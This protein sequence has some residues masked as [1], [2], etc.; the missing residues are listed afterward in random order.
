MPVTAHAGGLPAGHSASAAPRVLALGGE[1]FGDRPGGLNR[2]LAGLVRALGDAGADMRAV[3]LGPAVGAPSAFEAVSSAGAPLVRRLLAVRRAAARHAGAVDVVDVHFALYGLLPLLASRLR[4]VPVV[5][6]F[7]GPWAAESAV[8]GAGRVAVAAKRAVERA[9]Y[10]RADRVVVLSRAFGDIAVRDYGVDAAR[11]AVIPP[12]VDLDRF[13]PGDRDACRR[14]LGVGPATF[15]VVCARRLVARMGI[16]VLLRAWAQVQAEVPDAL[17]VIA[18]EGSARHGLAA[19]AAGVPRPDGVRLVGRVDDAVLTDLYRAADCTVVPTRALEGF[20]LVVL[21]S[22]ACGTPAV[23]AGV[24]GLPDAVAGLAPDLVVPAEDEQAL[25]ARLVAAACGQLPSRQRCRAH[26]ETFGW[27]EV[28]GRHTELLRQVAPP[29]PSG[30]RL[31][32]AYVDHCAVLSGAELALAR[33]LGALDVDAHVIL[34]EDGPLRARL[35]S[36][37]ATVHVL[38]M[39]TGL[40][41]LRRHRAGSVAAARHAADLALYVVRLTGLLRR[42]GP[43]VVHTNSLKAALYGG[44]AGRLAG[45]PVVWHVR[46]RIAPDYLP[47]AAVRLVRLAGRVLPSALIANS[48]GTL[49]TVLPAVA[50]P[51]PV[52]VGARRRRRSGGPLRVGIVGRLAP[53]KGQDVFLRAFARAFADDGTVAVVVGSALF[54]EEEYAGDLKTLVT[55]LGLDGRVE[56]RGFCDDVGAELARMDVVVHASTVPEPFGQVVVEAMAAGAAVVVPDRGG[57]A[58]V[59]EDGV[60]GVLYPMGDEDGLVAALHRVAGDAGLRARLGAAGRTAAQ[61]YRPEVVAG[62]V[63]SVYRAVLERAG[64]P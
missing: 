10:R 54:G 34:G 60:T 1:W 37:G 26:A 11:V 40:R 43:D 58:E 23:V 52:D 39:A 16:D 51:S 4:R 62:E 32:V 47:A 6:H 38:P 22:L 20:G 49:A 24:G 29:D 61:R 59:V 41:T 19:L 31:R 53:W 27:P 44:L 35:E 55:E 42:L 48:S 28:A 3:V 18:G 21:E 64:R 36:A 14:A 7:Q 56:L 5:V 57:P 45:V 8:G 17:L 50:I 63:S 12:G 2:Y 33:L 9:V 13:T 25:A 15:L 30:R 46:D